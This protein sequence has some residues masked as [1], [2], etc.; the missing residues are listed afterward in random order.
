MVFSY[1]VVRV[2]VFVSLSVDPGNM[3]QA[4]KQQKPQHHHHGNRSFSIP[5]CAAPDGA[6]SHVETCHCEIV[7]RTPFPRHQ[8]F[9]ELLVAHG[10]RGE[11]E[12]GQITH[13]E[14]SIENV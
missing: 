2:V 1:R 10:F 8:A 6:M 12:K 3:S 5:F 9:S 4:N 14:L 11:H 7:S 13:T